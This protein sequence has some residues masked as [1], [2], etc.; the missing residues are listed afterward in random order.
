MSISVHLTP[1]V[2]L[3]Y[4]YGG[5][6]VGWTVGDKAV[7]C[8]IYKKGWLPQSSWV[9]VDNILSREPHLWTVEDIIEVFEDRK[10]LHDGHCMMGIQ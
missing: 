3:R 10:Q 6:E 2:T 5:D 8:K 1:T 4:S 7:L 9:W